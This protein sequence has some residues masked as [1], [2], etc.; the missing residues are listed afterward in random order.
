M[1]R[2]LVVDDDHSVQ[3]MLVEAL[4]LHGYEVAACKDGSQALL[5]LSQQSY[6]LLLLDVLVP[7]LNGFTLMEELRRRPALR[8]LPVIL[9]SGIY[10][11]RNHRQEMTTRFGVIEYLD[12]PFEVPALVDLI[13]R[14]VGPGDAELAKETAVLFSEPVLL[15]QIKPVDLTEVRRRPLVRQEPDELLVDNSAK[16]EKKEVEA[17]ARR[18]FK[19][20]AFLLEGSLAASPVPALLGRLWNKRESGALLL[21]NGKVKKI[22]Y[23][24][25]GQPIFVRSNL[26]AECLGQLLVRERLITREDC[27]ASIE[28]MRK[29]GRKQGEILVERR[30]LTQKNLA[31]ALELQLEQKLFESFTWDEGEYRFNA[32]ATLPEG[33]SEPMPA[34]QLIAHGI[35]R[36]FDETRLRSYMLP[37]LDVPLAP[38]GGR[39]EL[40]DLQLLDHE[41]AAL[42][43]MP[44]PA[45]TRALLNE[46]SLDPP[47]SLRLLYT[48]IALDRLAPAR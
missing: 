19:K 32:S 17:S 20:S 39:P 23:L 45:T 22:V 31:F 44:L 15:D 2:L 26:V 42:E 5:E 34:P 8:E 6:D 40:A 12:K 48:L 21:R 30:C 43:T 14:A 25:A 33:G 9:M 38:R 18:D 46:L 47:D 41:L 4:R 24:R 1:P 28:Q 37:I 3:E 16:A 29:T 11:A 7:R 13:G 35:A 10:K 36:A 27:T